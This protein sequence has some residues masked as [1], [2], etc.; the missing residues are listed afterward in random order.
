ME[1]VVYCFDKF[2]STLT[3]YVLFSLN[4]FTHILQ[5]LPWTEVYKVKDEIIIVIRNALRQIKKNIYIKKC[6]VT[7]WP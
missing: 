4:K 6:R 1:K 2:I 5:D 3:A 7:S